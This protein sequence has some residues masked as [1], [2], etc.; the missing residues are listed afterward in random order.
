MI[1]KIGLTVGVLVVGLSFATMAY[2]GEEEQHKMSPEE[3]A[4]M[5]AW[6]KAATPGPHHARLQKS[7]GDWKTMVKVWHG[8]GEP[9][10][11]E[12]KSTIKSILGG[13]YVEEHFEGMAMGQPFTGRGI[14][15]YDNVTK[16]YTS[17]WMDSMSTS[18]LFFEGTYDESTNTL[19][20]YADAFDARNRW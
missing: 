2:S 10:V 3:A 16:R 8:A 7:V 17:L 12:G 20:Q 4:M 15:G 1:R 19:T 6:M 13:R 5:E 14:S 11:S 18:I 9:Q